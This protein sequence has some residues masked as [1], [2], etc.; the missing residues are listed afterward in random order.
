MKK[1]KTAHKLGVEGH[2]LPEKHSRR[3]RLAHRMGQ[4]SLQKVVSSSEALDRFNKE[5]LDS[6]ID[7]STDVNK[8]ALLIIKEAAKIPHQSA[9]EPSWGHTKIDEYGKHSRNWKTTLSFGPD[10]DPSRPSKTPLS[11]K[12]GQL[13]FD[14]ADWSHNGFVVP[15]DN[16]TIESSAP[17][18]EA[19]NIVGGART[20][21][22]FNTREYDADTMDLDFKNDFTE[23]VKIVVGPKGVIREF[24]M[25]RSSRSGY[26]YEDPTR[27]H[28]NLDE[29]LAGVQTSVQETARAYEGLGNDIS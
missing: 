29:F 25:S 10:Q 24:G 9:T 19:G 5:R 23:E 18:D 15:I 22:V 6:A 3:E 7:Q 14:T 21:F 20:I 1:I 26:S 17:E 4:K 16:L 2:P 13:R 28:V 8:Q 11:G 27:I 12:L